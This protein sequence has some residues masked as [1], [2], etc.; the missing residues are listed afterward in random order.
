MGF[1]V[2]RK[3]AKLQFEGEEF[4]GCEVVV[5]LEMSLRAQMQMDELKKAD[6]GEA[7]LAWFA[8]NCIISWNLTDEQDEPVALSAETFLTMPGWFTMPILDGWGKAVKFL[9][10]KFLP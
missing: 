5:S 8:E 7:I 9:F 10:L 3:T 6:D 4:E 2:P 1:K